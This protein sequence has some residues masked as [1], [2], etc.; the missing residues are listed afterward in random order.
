[1]MRK[2]SKVKGLIWFLLFLIGINELTYYLLVDDTAIPSRYI[3][4]H[5]Y[6]REENIDT[7]FLGTSHTMYGIDPDIYEEI[8]GNKAFN[9]GTNWQYLDGSLALIKEADRLYDLKHVYVDLYFFVCRRRNRKERTSSDLITAYYVSDYMKTSPN[10]YSYIISSSNSEHYIEGLIPQRRYIKNLTDF[11][12]IRSNINKKNAENYKKYICES[13]FEVIRENGQTSCVN[14]LENKGFYYEGIC[15]PIYDSQE[16]WY[17]WKEVLVEMIT[18]CQEHDITITFTALPMSDFFII[19]GGGVKYDGFVEEILEVIESSG[20]KVDYWDFNLAKK[21]YLD[22]SER[23]Y[24]DIS[25]L[26]AEGAK[27]VTALLADLEIK[28]NADIVFYDSYEERLDSK[29][30][31]FGMTFMVNEAAKMIE[32]VPA[33]NADEK[34]IT[35]K[36]TH[37]GHEI[38]IDY[39]NM[40]FQY[41]AGEE[42]MIQSYIGGE[43]C[44][45]IWYTG[46]EGS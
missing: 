1:M 26:N 44:N 30:T 39:E 10:K 29:K 8:T 3:L 27:R 38:E 7:L 23:D 15:N 17:D 9:C 37:S 5:F 22:L 21:K 6:E 36:V 28:D 2:F 33:T 46:K 4:H 14:S 41:E 42:Y 12:Y 32:L 34:D 31:V 13:E 35:Y 24:K 25:H 20:G 11:S 43:L 16:E 18:Y 40:A 45:V 19:Q